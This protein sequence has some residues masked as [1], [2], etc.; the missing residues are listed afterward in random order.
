MAQTALIPSEPV[1]V[2]LS[3]MGWIRAAKGHEIDP[4]SLSYK[5]GDTFQASALGRSNQQVV[6]L[7]SMGRSYTLAAHTLP[8]ARGQGDPLSGRFKPAPEATFK[9][10]IMASSKKGK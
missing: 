10:V 6:L 2:V 4:H 7:D 3:E 1:T 8:S 5:Q 9:S